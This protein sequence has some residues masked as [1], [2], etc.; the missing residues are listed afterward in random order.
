MP[1]REGGALAVCAVVQKGREPRVRVVMTNVEQNGTEG[2]SLTCGLD[3]KEALAFG[4][5]VCR[6]A[7]LAGQGQLSLQ[8]ALMEAEE[9][10]GVEPGDV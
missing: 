9:A 2:V 5:A 10:D 8:D 1:T 7:E 4:L 6:A 3:G